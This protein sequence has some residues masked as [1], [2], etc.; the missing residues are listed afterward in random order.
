[1]SADSESGFMNF[2]VFTHPISDV[3]IIIIIVLILLVKK[4]R[5]RHANYPKGTQEKLEK[6]LE[7]SQV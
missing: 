7:S 6:A 5:M 1:M 3:G 2:C 4:L